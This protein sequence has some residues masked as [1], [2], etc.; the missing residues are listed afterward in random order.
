MIESRKIEMEKQC[1]DQKKLD[2][3]FDKL[4]GHISQLSQ[5]IAGTQSREKVTPGPNPLKRPAPM[6]ETPDD[7]GQP[8]YQASSSQSIAPPLPTPSMAEELL[9]GLDLGHLP[10]LSGRKPR[11]R[12]QV[13]FQALGED[14]EEEDKDQDRI[15]SLMERLTASQEATAAVLTR[16]GS[17]GGGSGEDP[18]FSTIDNSTLR[19]ARDREATRKRLDTKPREVAREHFQACREEVGS[20][21]T[22]PFDMDLYAQLALKEEFKSHSTLHRAWKMNAAVHRLLWTGKYDRAL[23]Q[24]A[25]NLKAIGRAAKAGGVWAGAWELTHLTDLN[26]MEVGVSLEEQASTLRYLKEKSQMA[27]LLEE[28]R[29]K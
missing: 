13:C 19:S 18:L 29:K 21:P 14:D 8:C 2:D 22:H 15:E 23:A 5:S 24:T 17:G 25:Q 7:L 10:Q 1:Q 6:A 4:F 11:G 12:R 28:A 20:Q 16:L 27:K 26:E 3:K 9:G